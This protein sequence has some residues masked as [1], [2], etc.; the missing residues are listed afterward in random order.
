LLRVRS[1]ARSIPQ[2]SPDLK[3]HVSAFSDAWV[4]QV[5]RLSRDISQMVL[6]GT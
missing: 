3:L 1:R 4:Y 6:G 2:S 5:L